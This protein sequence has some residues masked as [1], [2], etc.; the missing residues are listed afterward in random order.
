M[1]EHERTPR[2]ASRGE[3]SQEQAI[4]D[5]RLVPERA[6]DV[7]APGDPVHVTGRDRHSY[8]VLGS[9]AVEEVVQRM[10]AST[11]CGHSVS[12]IH[13]PIFSNGGLR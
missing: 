4:L 2:R 12:G 3:H 1:R 5:V 9:E 7:P 13:A 8:A 11:E 10:Q 6:A